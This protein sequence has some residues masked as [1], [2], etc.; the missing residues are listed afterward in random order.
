MFENCAAGGQDELVSWQL[1]LTIVTGQPDVKQIFLFPQF[2]EGAADVGL[3]I[4][5]SQTILFS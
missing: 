2:L 3:K 5:P 1:N 4:I